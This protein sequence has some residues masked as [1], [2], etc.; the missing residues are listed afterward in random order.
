MHTISSLPT[1]VPLSAALS[2]SPSLP[3]I[4]LVTYL[5]PVWYPQLL[6]SPY[7]VVLSRDHHSRWPKGNMWENRASWFQ[8]H[9]HR[10]QAGTLKK[11]EEIFLPFATPMQYALKSSLKRSSQRWKVFSGLFLFQVS[12]E[13]ISWIDVSVFS[14]KTESIGYIYEEIYLKELAHTI[15]GD[16]RSEICRADWQAGNSGRRWQWSLEA[17]LSFGLKKY[18]TIRMNYKILSGNWQSWMLT[19]KWK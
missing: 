15:M 3:L 5:V 9:Q 19:F 1:P 14:R 6:R 16:G 17:E 8:D 11:N 13:R 10:K 2:A 12:T 4:T 18:N 7:S